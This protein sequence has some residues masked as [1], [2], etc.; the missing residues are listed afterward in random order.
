MLPPYLTDAE[1]ADITYPLVQ[2]AAR[3]RFFAKTGIAVRPRPD[4]QPLVWRVDFEAH[5]PRTAANDSAGSTP[6]W[7]GLDARMHGGRKSRHGQ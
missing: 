3:V 2:G 6:D 4:G 1:I 7:A 5:R